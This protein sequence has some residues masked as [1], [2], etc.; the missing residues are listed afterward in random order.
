MEGEGLMMVRRITAMVLMA[1]GLGMFALSASA[2]EKEA[3]PS[4]R[5]LKKGSLSAIKT[6]KR[7]VVQDEKAYAALWTQHSG[8]S[9]LDGEPRPAPSVDFKTEMVLAVFLGEKRTGGYSVEIKDAQ[10]TGGNLVVTVLEK[11][12]G[13]GSIVTEALTAPYCFV[14]VKRST[15]AV[16]WKV[17]KDPAK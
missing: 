11:S 4:V 10:E 3:A 6:P 1:V 14:A 15:S 8:D 7:V 5:L 2:A 17:V 12:P 13:P 9:T 16:Q